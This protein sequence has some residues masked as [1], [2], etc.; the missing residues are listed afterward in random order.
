[1]KHSII[2]ISLL[3]AVAAPAAAFYSSPVADD[4]WFPS[5]ELRPGVTADVHV[6]L[7]QNRGRCVGTVFAVHGVAH[8]AATW[9]PFAQALFAGDVLPIKPCRV[10]AI[11]LPGH[12]LSGLPSGMLFGELS[13]YDYSSAII[14]VLQELRERGVRVGIIVGHS[15][16]GLLVQTVQERLLAQ[17]SSLRAAFGIGG[18]LLL[19]SAL[20]S[21]VQVGQPSD[22]DLTPFIVEQPALGVFL[23]VPDAIWPQA[24][25]INTVGALADGAPSPAEVAARGYNSFEPIAALFEVVD[26]TAYVRARAFCDKGTHLTLVFN[27]S[28]PHQ[29]PVSQEALFEHLTC[30]PSLARMVTMTGPNAVHDA[31]VAVPKDLLR[32]LTRW[33]RR[34]A[35]ALS[36]NV[37]ATGH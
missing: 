14:G 26:R 10:A 32:A 18:A 9:E 37:R 15:M 30:R 28:D 22:I 3:G 33:Q 16:G 19:A 35:R 13:L 21:A 23:A 17:G 6:H 2:A 27:E 25:F 4:L 1:M 29:D 7:F 12:G 5:I 31:H 34:F 8:T 11:D 36:A 24:Y 20:P